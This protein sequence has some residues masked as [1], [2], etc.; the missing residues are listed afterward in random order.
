MA[1]CERKPKEIR[2]INVFG[3][4]ELIKKLNKGKPHLVF[5]LTN[6]VFDGKNPMQK[7]DAPRNPIN[8]YGRQKAEVERFVENLSNT[9]ILR[10]TKVI[11]V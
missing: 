7:P 9:C 1:T 11:Q 5:I 6:Q 4:I 3:T 8:E 2:T 10:L